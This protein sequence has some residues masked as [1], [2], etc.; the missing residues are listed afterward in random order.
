[1]GQMDKGLDD[2]VKIARETAAQGSSGHEAVKPKNA[3]PA[4][5][6]SATQEPAPQPKAPKSAPAAEGQVVE[7]VA[8]K[9]PEPLPAQQPAL[10]PAPESPSQSKSKGLDRI[11]NISKVAEKTLGG[12]THGEEKP[13][14]QELQ[15]SPAQVMSLADKRVER[16]M[17]GGHVQQQQM[18]SS[19]VVALEGAEKPREGWKAQARQNPSF[20]AHFEGKAQGKVTQMSSQDRHV[21][22]KMLSMIMGLENDGKQMAA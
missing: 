22:S 12:K 8:Q 19:N 20:A 2:M 4:I 9:A 7:K 21:P 5:E 13:Q 6:S 3:A 18:F 10:Q 11:A 16:S 1:M 14:Q 15:K 17:G